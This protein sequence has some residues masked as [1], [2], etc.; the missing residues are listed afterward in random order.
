MGPSSPPVDKTTAISPRELYGPGTIPLTHTNGQGLFDRDGNTV[1][2]RFRASEETLGIFS[3]HDSAA[4]LEFTNGR[5]DSVDVTGNTATFTG[6]ARPQGQGR[7]TFAVTVT[8]NGPGG[9][10]DTIAITLSN[11]YS[12]SGTLTS[13]EIRIF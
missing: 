6:T 9:T 4:G 8:D 3:L 10:S 2:F 5:I 1:E 7:V 11:G 13:G 12:A